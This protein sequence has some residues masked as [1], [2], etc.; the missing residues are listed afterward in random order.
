MSKK[1]Y[2]I[3]DRVTFVFIGQERTGTIIDF[4]EEKGWKIK[5]DN[6]II[7]PHVQPG[8]GK[9]IVAYMGPIQN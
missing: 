9:N 4:H 6:G 3:G 8:P 1:K 7:V 2:S 5:D